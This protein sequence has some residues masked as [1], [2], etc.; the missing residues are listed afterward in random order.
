MPPPAI[1]GC[2]GF[3]L[4]PTSARFDRDLLDCRV[5]FRIPT[6]EENAAII[7]FAEQFRC[8][9]SIIEKKY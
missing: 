6:V 1:P 8:Q 4:P 3:F 9:A 7:F 2:G 5:I